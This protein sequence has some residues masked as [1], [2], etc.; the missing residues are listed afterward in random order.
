MAACGVWFACDNTL[1]PACE[2]TWFLL[3]VA[4]S[5][6]MSTS[7]MRLFAAE[8]FKRTDWMFEIVVSKRFI[9]APKRARAWLTLKSALSIVSRA[10]RA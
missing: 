4:A 3:W 5:S 2:S 6:A 9:I 10:V 8:R 1:V 7:R